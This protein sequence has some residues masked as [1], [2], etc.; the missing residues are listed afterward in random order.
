[1]VQFRV[2]LYAYAVA[3]T[4]EVVDGCQFVVRYCVEVAAIGRPTGDAFHI[5][6]LM[7]VVTKLVAQFVDPL[8]DGG[9]HPFGRPVAPLLVGHQPLFSLG[10]HRIDHPTVLRRIV[11]IHLVERG[12]TPTAMFMYDTLLDHFLVT[13]IVTRRFLQQSPEEGVGM[14]FRL[15]LGCCHTV[16]F[17]NVI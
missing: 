1:M 6:Q 10:L 9:D 14:F 2:T 8:A 11:L 16:L 15:S 5:H 7:P 3:L 4:I 13:R 12:G 17:L